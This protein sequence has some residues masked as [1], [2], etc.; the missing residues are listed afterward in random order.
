MLVERTT[1]IG[2]PTVVIRFQD[3]IASLRLLCIRAHGHSSPRIEFSPVVVR[4]A[5]CGLPASLDPAARGQS[6]FRRADSGPSRA[7]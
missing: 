3:Q 7:E 4:A 5:D 1:E 6:G 2:K